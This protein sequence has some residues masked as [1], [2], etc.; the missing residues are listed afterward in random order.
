MLLAATLL[1]DFERETP[2]TRAVLQAVPEEHFAYKP[3]EKSMSLGALAGHI[4][5]STFW[6][7]AMIKGSM[8][9]D[10]MMTD[11]KPFVPS[12]KLELMEVFEKNVAG[13]A[14]LLAG[15]DDDFM[16]GSFK[17]T[18]GDEVI[19]EQ[20]RHVALRSTGV[21][22]QLHHRAQLTVYLRLLDVAVPSTYGPTAD[23]RLE[24]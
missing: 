19:M 2:G 14:T 12:T 17:M 3:H 20:P 5:E 6:L 10:T 1:A 22:H 13:L 11:Y 16:N 7:H 18:K 24:G 23:D 21:H 15:R 4:A 8:D 9:V